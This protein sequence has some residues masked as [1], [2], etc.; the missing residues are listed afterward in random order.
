MYIESLKLFNF[1]NFNYLNIDFSKSVNFIVGKN[2]QGKTNLIES[3]YLLST[4]KSFRKG[5]NKNLIRNEEKEGSIFGKIISDV[6]NFELGIVFRGN[7]K[8][9]YYNQNKVKNYLDFIGKIICL[10]FTPD[11]LRLVKGEPALRRGFLDHL[12]VSIN[13]SIF[14]HLVEYNRA[15]KSKNILLKNDLDLKYELI[16]PWNRIIAEKTVLIEKERIKLLKNI[17]I[18]ANKQHEKFSKTDGNIELTLNGSFINEGILEVDSIDSI[19]REGFEREKRRG[20]SVF[21]LHKD[22]I[23]I[24]LGEKEAKFFSSQGQTRS[25]VLSLKLASISI[26]EKERSIR[27]IILLD[28]VNSE[29]DQTRT[30]NFFEMLDLEKGQV[31]VTG[32]DIALSK[33]L[34]GS[35][36][37]LKISEGTLESTDS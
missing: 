34:K 36:R 25:L 5:K 14:K 16:E 26:I 24:N 2:G 4:S 11:D 13:P 8:E 9:A 32:T 6:S 12:L 22:D 10:S 18:E 35:K 21:G 29:L 23:I 17:Q 1:R 3:L 28:D 33:L 30:D 37:V 31:F 27:P 15:I 19:L 20:Y 7:K